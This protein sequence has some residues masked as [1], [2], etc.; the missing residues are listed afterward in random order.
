[1]TNEELSNGLKQL[2]LPTMA[3]GYNEASRAAEKGRLTYEQYLAGLVDE[4]LNSKYELRIKRLS[5]EAKLPLEKRI[6]H[7]DFTQREGITEGEFKRLA[8]GDFVRDGSNIVFYGSFGVGKTHLGIA[9][10][11]ELVK[12]NVRCLFVS[13]HGLI[14]QMLEAKKNLMLQHLFKR[15][16]RYDL[17]VCDEL[18]YIAQTQDGA[19]LFFQILSLR[20]ERKSVLITTNL[21]FSEWDRVFINPLNTAAAIDRIIHKCETFNIKGPSWRAEEAKKR[22]KIKAT[23]ADKKV[24]PS[25]KTSS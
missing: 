8:K 16:D 20:A 14:E 12:K 6:E 23:L 24:Q 4:E 25:I 7:F 10:I 5:K 18:G 21:T 13:T 17:L 1:M 2:N 22:T 19:D 15:L 9:L 11:K 3:E